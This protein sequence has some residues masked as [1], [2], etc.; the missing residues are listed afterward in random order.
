V[1]FVR[2]DTQGAFSVNRRMELG[3]ALGALT[4]SFFRHNAPDFQQKTMEVSGQVYDFLRHG[5]NLYHPAYQRDGYAAFKRPATPSPAAQ[6]ALAALPKKMFLN[7]PIDPHLEALVFRRPDG[8]TMGTLTRFSCHPVCMSDCRTRR[9]SADFPGVLTRELA[10]ATGAPALFMNGPSGDLK[11]LISE[12]TPAE[13]ERVG[14]GLAALL[15][16][17][18]RSAIPAPLTQCTFLRHE[19]EFDFTPD[20]VNVSKEQL[21]EAEQSFAAMAAAPFDPPELRRKLD[22]LL[23]MWAACDCYGHKKSRVPLAFYRVDFNDASL[24]AMPG[25]VFTAV[26]LRLKERFP[27][28]KLVTVMLADTHDAGYVPLREDFPLG[29]YEVAASCLP[30]GGAE[31][32]VEIGAQLLDGEKGRRADGETG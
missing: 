7:R 5:S 28:R 20:V 16:D 9:I 15:T 6:R 2:I 29:G 26:S 14:R 11:P 31:R 12:N 17:A 23:R 22:R 8:R 27:Q 25:E 30:P 32:M 1:A 24:L 18:L 21:A 19:E 10:A 13:M 4:I 3:Q